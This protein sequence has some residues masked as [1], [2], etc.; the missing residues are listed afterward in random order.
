MSKNYV[1]FSRP[2][3]SPEGSGWKQQLAR[4][5]NDAGGASVSVTDDTKTPKNKVCVRL[6]GQPSDAQRS[7]LGL[8]K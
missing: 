3:N 5:L 4:S 1:A 6:Q 7:I 8:K 2:S